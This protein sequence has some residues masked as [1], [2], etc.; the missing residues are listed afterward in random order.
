MRSWSVEEGVLVR[1]FAGG[2]GIYEVRRRGG[3]AALVCGSGAWV[4]GRARV[5][6]CTVALQVSWSRDGNRV[7]ACFADHVIYVL[8]MHK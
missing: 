5:L 7:A 3:G 8:D 1:T 4:R 2:S 6:A